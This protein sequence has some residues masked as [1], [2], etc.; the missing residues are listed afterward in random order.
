MPPGSVLSSV[1][2]AR[3]GKADPLPF[4]TA[5]SEKNI[6]RDRLHFNPYNFSR[7]LPH[8][9]IR[10]LP[11]TTNVSSSPT[12]EPLFSATN[13]PSPPDLLS[14]SSMGGSVWIK[15]GI[16]WKERQPS[17]S[18]A[19]SCLQGLLAGRAGNG[20]ADSSADWALCPHQRW[21]Q[22]TSGPGAQPS[23][24]FL[25]WSPTSCFRGREVGGVGPGVRII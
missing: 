20:P 7:L 9:S 15:E 11:L 8:P 4:T 10:S 24:L 5:N 23:A 21:I 22:L 16:L 14:A 1:Q 13:P 19:L 6:F 3:Q 18:P 2:G 17:S 25:K 12:P